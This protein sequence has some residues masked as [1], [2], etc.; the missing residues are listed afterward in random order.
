MT[1]VNATVSNALFARQGDDRFASLDAMIA[2]ARDRQARASELGSVPPEA[3][4]F[5]TTDDRDSE[6]VRL[7]IDHHSARHVPSKLGLTNYSLGQFCTAARA[8]MPLLERLSRQT[9]ARVLNES[10]RSDACALTDRSILI[11]TDPAAK[12]LID[13]SS[14]ELLHARGET[15]R[16]RAI[17]SDRYARVWDADLF[18]EVDRWLSPVGYRPA[19]PTFNYDG[20]RPRDIFGDDRPAL[21]SGDRDSFAFFYT[22]PDPNGNDFGG[23]R[24][25]IYIGNSEVGARSVMWSTFYFRDMCAN[26]LVWGMEG[27]KQRRVRHVGQTRRLQTVYCRELRRLA[28]EAQPIELE[29]IGRAARTAFATGS[30]GGDRVQILA[31]DRLQK[32]FGL[33]KSLAAETVAAA[34]L[35]QNAAQTGDPALSHWTIANGLTWVAKDTAY[36]H[37]LITAGS[38]AEAIVRSASS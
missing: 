24:R 18:G 22:D 8:P 31:A 38:M 30:T 16:V 2:H 6:P 12:D 34:L 15:A 33:S 10:I 17:T 21:W 25:G 14:G 4:I 13:A 27:Q 35:P 3:L 36:A 19:V 11:E 28:E 7:T 32:Q 26:F 1:T 23:L 20:D 9:I 37:D 29:T 5:T